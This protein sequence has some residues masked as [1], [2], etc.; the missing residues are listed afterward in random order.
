[1]K[2]IITLFL[3]T[4]LLMLPLSVTASASTVDSPKDA[5]STVEPRLYKKVTV[6]LGNSWADIHNE[7]NLFSADL[8][9]ENF[10]TS[11]YDVMVRIVSRDHATVIASE[12][13]IASGKSSTFYNLPSGGYIIQ[14]KS[15]DD[16]SREYTLRLS[17]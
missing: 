10:A 7:S 11:G 3:V 15:Y 9:V 1:M 14:A 17:D 5:S 2:R 4:A 8:L 13:T 16:V 12:K 6:N